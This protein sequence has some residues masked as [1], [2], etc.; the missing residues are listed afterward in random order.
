MLSYKVPVLAGV[1]FA[2]LALA[3]LGSARDINTIGAT[4]KVV[5]NFDGSDGFEPTGVIFDAAGNLYG[6]TTMGSKKGCYDQFGCGLVFELMPNGKVGWTEKILYEF[7]PDSN[8]GIYPN[9]G[10]V[11]DT[12][13]NLYGLTSGGGQQGCT[14]DGLCGTVFKLTPTA[15]GRWIKQ[16]LHYFDANGKDGNDPT[17]GLVMD[18]H[19]NLYGTTYYGGTGSCSDGNGVG[20]GTVFELSP[21]TRKGGKWTETILYSFQ[22][23]ATDGIWPDATL[24]LDASGNLYGENWGG[25]SGGNGT[26]FELVRKKGTWTERI[27]HSFSGKDGVN[28]GAGLVFDADGDLYST[29]S[30]GG[31]GGCSI[32]GY[33][34]CGTVFKIRP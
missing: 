23:N 6:T 25:G 29:T 27:L 12:A 8:D 10:L 34:G 33:P 2:L 3:P 30:S 5:F 18:A 13:G 1:A 16:V 7:G 15:H 22:N 31:T 14:S 21:P 17:A 9:G 4:E 28:P 24:L 26:V 32:G 19:G 11:F 20:C